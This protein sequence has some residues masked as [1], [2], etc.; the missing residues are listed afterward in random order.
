[1]RKNL[2]AKSVAV[3]I[4][5]FAVVGGAHAVVSFTPVATAPTNGIP[6]A[7]VLEV[8]T[9]A[10][11]HSLLFPY[12]TV[13][14]DNVTLMS[15]VNTDM[16]NGKA[17]KV[18]FRGAENSDD[19]F[20]ITVL[21]SPG[22]VWT[23]NVSREEPSGLAK[24]F[25]ADRTCTL[26]ANVNSV[27]KTVRLPTY[28]SSVQNA[29]S[30]REG[31]IEVFNMGDIPPTL[32]GGGVNPLFTA[33]KHTSAG[34]PF[35]CGAAA[36][37]TLSTTDPA[38]PSG[39]G[40]AESLGLAA[41]TT[42]LTGASLILQGSNATSYG[43]E[44]VAIEARAAAGGVPGYAN[45]V[46]FPQVDQPVAS[47]QQ[48]TADPVLRGGVVDNS[49]ALGT[50]TTA[51][52]AIAKFFDYPDMSTPYLSFAP[53]LAGV[54]TGAAARRQAYILSRAL[55][56]S[57][58]MNEYVTGSG[59]G[60]QTD[61]TLSSPSRRYN[62]ARLY[63][64]SAAA[65]T[66]TYTNYGFDDANVAVGTVTVPPGT[67]VTPTNFYTPANIEVRAVENVA[68]VICVKSTAT[69]FSGGATDFP[70]AL[71]PNALISGQIGNREE[72]FMGLNPTSTAISPGG[73]LNVIQG[74]CGE[75]SIMSFNNTSQ[76]TTVLIAQLTR[77]NQPSDF[78][79]GWARIATPGLAAGAGQGLGGSTRMG[80]PII[81]HAYMKFVNTTA[82]GTSGATTTGT[83]ANYDGV[84][85]H[86]STRY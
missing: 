57:S 54:A 34:V 29:A 56:V 83:I 38:A 45:I 33:I 13:Q 43:T 64:A 46:Y 59:I 47:S 25:T 30:T 11:G 1:M 75:V 19:L 40:G 37:A 8:N 84:Y 44:A 3:L 79:A 58:V 28:N 7:Q 61:W 17:I 16:L 55:A 86:R 78:E 26:P 51:P 2:L 42:G 52:G 36:V 71:A 62:V 53:T 50:P 15:I 74:L 14:G 9:D 32:V 77:F 82:A 20:D 21:M 85:K 18:R 60:A 67:V 48:Y 35:N 68:G 63:G 66:T 10:I 69:T 31:Y 73:G 81:G 5:G 39:A 41:A 70:S 80:L 49:G 4:S 72:Q 23:A 6:Q 27:F 76:P 12:Y 24:L 22:D 65:A